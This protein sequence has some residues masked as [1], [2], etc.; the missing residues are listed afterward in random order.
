MIF[1]ALFGDPEVDALLSDASLVAAML[2]VEVALAT[3]EAAASVIPA[4][5][6][7]AIER[8]ANV[9]DYD[10]SALAAE[11]AAAGNLAIPLVHRLTEHVAEVDAESAKY[12]HWGATSQDVIDSATVLQLRETIAIVLNS[13]AH[14]GDAAAALAERHGTTVLAGR[15]WLQQ[16]TPITFGLKAAGWMSALDRVHASITAALSRA[17][18]LQFG[19]ASGTL[20]ALGDRGPDV[21]TAMGAALGLAVPELPWHAHRDRLAMLAC[22]LGVATG[23]MGK[24]ARDISLLGQT[25]VAEAFE[26]AVDGRGESSTMPQKRNP[27]GA[28]V[29][30]AASVR[31]PGLV[32]TMLAAMPQEHERGLGGWQAEWETL[33]ELVHL[34]AGAARHMAEM[35]AKLKVDANRMRLNVDM[36]GGVSLAESVSMALAKHVGKAEAHRTIQAASRRAIAE[37]RTLADVLSAM[38]EVTKYLS[39]DDLARSLNADRYLGASAQFVRAALATRSER[40]KAG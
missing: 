13:L 12:V 28:S 15:T 19:G 14:A 30:L 27:V 34:T 24:I 7:A 3:A 25:E 1:D 18:V 37:H 6:V 23:A 32:A 16:A 35:L 40:H 31:A 38:P 26:G 39:T 20:A 33:P 5:A 10:L 29:V 11:S 21:A 36:T 17:L 8:S 4:G 2:R 9:A 22:T